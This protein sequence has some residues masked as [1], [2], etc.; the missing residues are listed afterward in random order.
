LKTGREL[1]FTQWW[2]QIPVADNS[3]RKYC[4]VE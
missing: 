1:I 4:K 3:F 2:R